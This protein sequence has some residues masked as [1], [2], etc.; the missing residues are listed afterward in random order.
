[1]Q[2]PGY[3]EPMAT[4]A[5]QDGN[6]RL[7]VWASTQSVFLARARLAEALDRP[8]STIRVIQAVT[9][10]GFGAKIVEES[11]SLIAALLATRL[12]RPVRFVNNRLED[13]LGARSSVPAR[14]WLKM[15]LDAQGMIVAKDVNIVAECGAYA[16][17]A[18]DVM[19]VTAM[20]S[21]N[22]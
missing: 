6:G 8:V 11:N 1:S 22:M 21:D 2:Y 9:G 10:G 17:L 16:G 7:T 4:V 20:R 13:F 18:G 12:D 14:V 19:H 3:L 15:G 5:A